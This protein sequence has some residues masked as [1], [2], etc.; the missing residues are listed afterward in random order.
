MWLA[1]LDQPGKFVRYPLHLLLRQHLAF[2]QAGSDAQHQGRIARLHG[3]FNPVYGYI[4]IQQIRQKRGTRRM[5]D[6]GNETI[7]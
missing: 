2:R 5:S 1:Q 6:G 3:H 7:R 4:H